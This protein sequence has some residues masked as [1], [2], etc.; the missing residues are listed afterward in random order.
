MSALVSR[1]LRGMNTD[2]HLTVRLDRETPEQRATAEATL[3]ACAAWLATMERTCSR[4]LPESELRALN[5]SAGTPF[6]ASEDLFAVI[7]LALDAAARTGG[8][9]DP[10][11]LPAL[12]AAGYRRSFD[13]IAHREI[14]FIA[15]GSRRCTP[16][17]VGE[18]PGE[19]SACGPGEIVL[20]VACRTIALP[21]G[22]ALDLGGIAK[23]WAADELARRFLAP[24]PAYLIDL[25]G[26]LRVLGGPAP[27]QSWILGIAD[28]RRATEEVHCAATAPES[29]H[30]AGVA[31]ASGGIATSGDA[32]R[33]WLRGGERMHH[34]IDPRTGRP[35]AP[36]TDPSQRRVLTYTALAPTTAVA[37]V[38]AKVAFLCGYPDGLRTLAQGTRTA[39]VCVFADGSLEA[40]PNLEEYLHA[41][42][43]VAA[44]HAAAS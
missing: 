27:D 23:G 15:L 5:A 11:I 3:D 21:A 37:D 24:F 4:F 13:Q 10:T 39:G 38:L 16:P 33:W 19:R 40:T 28:P 12:H 14:G 31:L 43:A 1:K 26:D 18:G 20:D 2:L 30:V 17:P 42:Q 32:R 29:A 7:S 25:G 35:A 41:A 34:L 44:I 8:L 36:P 9:F 22:L 6:H